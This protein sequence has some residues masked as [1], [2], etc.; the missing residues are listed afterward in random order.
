VAEQVGVERRQ[1]P[2][3]GRRGAGELLAVAGQQPGSA[4]PRLDFNQLLSQRL[5]SC[6]PRPD[7]ADSHPAGV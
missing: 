1:Q 4:A 3:L 2:D 6:P 7:L 5:E